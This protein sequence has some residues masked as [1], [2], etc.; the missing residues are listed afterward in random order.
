MRS[1]VKRL[2]ATG[3]AALVVG[4]GGCTTVTD[5]ATGYHLTVREGGR[6]LDE[7]D[8]ARLGELPQTEITTP[9][10]RGNPVQRGPTVRAVLDAAGATDVRSVRFEGSDPAQTLTAAELSDRVVLSFTRRDTLKLAGVDL[11]RD[12]W[13]RDVNTVVVNP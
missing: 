11:D 13:V 4:A 6:M 9:Q 8:L 3:L 1:S 7:F 2:F 5:T 10:S 12:R